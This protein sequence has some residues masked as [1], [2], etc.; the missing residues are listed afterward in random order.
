MH[1]RFETFPDTT[2]A[3]I[4]HRGSYHDVGPVFDRVIDWAKQHGL[5]TPST[6][7]IGLPYDNPDSVPV[8]ELRYDA[9]VSMEAPVDVSDE[10]IK[11]ER[12]P[13]GRYA[14]YTHKGPYTG[15]AGAFDKLFGQWLPDSG[16]ELDER[17]CLEM[18]LNDCKTLPEGEWLTDLC[19]P[20]K[21]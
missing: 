17:P 12:I 20:L 4:R 9:G 21:A 8:E 14:V 2:F 1:V 13:A 7:I 6:K 3:C 11:I 5:Y 10:S 15:I 19:I 18:Y 16:E